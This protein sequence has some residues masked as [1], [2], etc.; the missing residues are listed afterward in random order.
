MKFRIMIPAQRIEK[1]VN[2]GWLQEINEGGKAGCRNERRA[3]WRDSRIRVLRDG[4]SEVNRL[5]LL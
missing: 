2:G 3:R 4:D 1:M 5:C